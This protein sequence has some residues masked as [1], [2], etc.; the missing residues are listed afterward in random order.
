MR[1]PA[2]TVDV[3]IEFPDGDI[4]LIERGNDPFKGRA[5]LPGGFVE[6]GETVETAAIREAKEETGLDIRL[7][8]LVGVYSDPNRDPRGHTVS[9]VFHATAVGGDLRADTDAA[10]V[11]RT[12]DYFSRPLAFDH[13]QI[14]KDAFRGHKAQ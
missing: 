4:I 10:N 1:N 3:V 11:F 12:A 7:D 9:V 5:A 13:E 14:L 8:R 2:L 6:Y